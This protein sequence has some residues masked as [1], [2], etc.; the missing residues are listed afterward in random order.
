MIQSE[1]AKAREANLNKQI[2]EAYEELDNI[3]LDKYGMDIKCLLECHKEAC[4]S[5]VQPYSKS[6][7]EQS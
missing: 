5:P 4:M 1:I 2:K 7:L 6:N 3:C